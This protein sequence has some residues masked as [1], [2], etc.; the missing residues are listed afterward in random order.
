MIEINYVSEG[1]EKNVI[2]NACRNISDEEDKKMIYVSL[3]SQY[4]GTAIRLVLCRNCAEELYDKIG[5]QFRWN[6]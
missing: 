6:I 3:K 1:T 2:C 4:S 5:E